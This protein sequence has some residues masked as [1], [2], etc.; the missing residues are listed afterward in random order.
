MEAYNLSEKEKILL[1]GIA[2]DLD[3]DDLVKKMTEEELYVYSKSLQNYGLIIAHYRD[4]QQ[5]IGAQITIKGE[6]YLKENPTLSPPVSAD[7]ELLQKQNLE[8][9]NQKLQYEEDLKGLQKRLYFWQFA[10]ALL[11]VIGFAV[12][13]LMNFVK[14]FM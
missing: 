5:M 12:G 11:T 13:M 2:E 6:V 10:S 8:L 3:I 1:V 9:Q 7:I 14:F 4:P